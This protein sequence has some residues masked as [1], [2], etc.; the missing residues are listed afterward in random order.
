MV[1]ATNNIER[2]R[3]PA[4]GIANDNSLTNVLALNGTTLGYV[5]DLI[6]L[7]GTQTLS[8]KSFSDA[9]PMFGGK[10]TESTG[11]QTTTDGSTVTLVTISFPTSNTVGS[12][13]MRVFGYATA[14]A[15][16]NTTCAQR[17]QIKVNNVAGTL[18]QGTINNS[19]SNAFTTGLGVVF[20]GTNALVQVTGTV[21]NTIR[22]V[23]YATTY[24]E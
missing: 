13:D 4:G 19:F 18:S 20:S 8:N 1:F 21:T 5:N 2:L 3:I 6:D 15:L 23:A 12:L 7:T 16:A 22:W 10:K 11:T 9:P 17:L 24:Y 14:G